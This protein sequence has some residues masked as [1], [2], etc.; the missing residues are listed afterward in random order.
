MSRAYIIANVHVNDLDGY[1]KYMAG[2][3]ATV[4]RYGGRFVT[5]GGP[6]EFL[7][8]G[9]EAAP[10][11]VIVEFDSAESAKTWYYSPEYTQL[12]KLRQSYSTGTFILAEAVPS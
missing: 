10:R 4:D 6:V 8:G 7:E 9:S 3:P 2:V 1:K 11:V 12:R 5:R